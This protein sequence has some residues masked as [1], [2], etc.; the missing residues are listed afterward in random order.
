VE[1]E[2][3]TGGVFYRSGPSRL[4][5]YQSAYAGHAQHTLASWDVD[6]LESIVAELTGKG[7]SFETYDLPGLTT[8][9]RGIADLGAEKAAWFKDPDGNILNVSQSTAS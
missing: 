6:D 4:Y 9:E 3:P 1:Q 7:V 8:D 5:L 2:D